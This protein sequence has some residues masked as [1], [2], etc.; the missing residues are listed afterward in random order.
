VYLIAACSSPNKTNTV[1]E[2]PSSSTLPTDTIAQTT[3]M[4]EKAESEPQILKIPVIGNVDLAKMNADSLNVYS[5]RDCSGTV[6]RYSMPRVDFAIDSA[7]C[8]A[9]DFSYSYYLLNPKDFLQIVYTKKST[10]ILNPV[11]NTYSYSLE[12]QVMDFTTDSLFLMIKTD[13]ISDYE[14]REKAID[15]FFSFKILEDKQEIYEQ[16]ESRYKSAWKKD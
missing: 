4:L 5:K 3:K 10:S 14:Q 1:T 8:G 6:R 16:F 12:E 2:E 9:N 15:K 7:T 11:T 13:T